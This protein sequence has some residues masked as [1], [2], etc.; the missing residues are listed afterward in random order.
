MRSSRGADLGIDVTVATLNNARTIG[1]CLEA[2]RENVPMSR[3]II[4][5]GGSRDGTIELATKYGAQVVYERGL[6][7]RVRCVQAQQCETEWV[8]YFDSDVY[9]YKAWWPEV[10]SYIG[11]PNVGMV[12][13]FAEA[14]IAK[15]PEYDAFLNYRARK[16]GTEA[17]SNTLVRRRLVLECE[18]ALMG[19]HA[20]EDSV[21]A[22]HIEQRGYRVVTIPKKLCFH[23]PSI[24][25]AHVH[26]YFRSGQSIRKSNG[27][28]G[29]L[30]MAISMRTAVR[31]WWAFNRQTGKFNIALLAYL[32]KLYTWM[33]IGFLS[34]PRILESKKTLHSLDHK[35]VVV[36]SQSQL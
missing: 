20:G 19:V 34:D 36:T 2:I 29:I 21:V 26:A 3:L 32:G 31:D 9:V 13:G 16:F 30:R 14:G 7:G 35:L 24:V 4:V 23:D 28:V 17:F 33:I 11:M 22:R 18:S 12:V 27:V 10:S 1:R 25:E 5:D 8:A 15:L 6:L